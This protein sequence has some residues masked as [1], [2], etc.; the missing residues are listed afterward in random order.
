MAVR[1]WLERERERRGEV[2]RLR[3]GLKTLGTS[4]LE[5]SARTEDFDENHALV[6]FESVH[7]KLLPLAILAKI[8]DSHFTAT[9]R[10]FTT[11]PIAFFQRTRFANSFEVAS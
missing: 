4:V 7:V 11:V 3:R 2:A 9:F 5:S 6:L 10:N 8:L 1:F